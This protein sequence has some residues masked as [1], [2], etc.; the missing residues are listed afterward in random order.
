MARFLGLSQLRQ[1][2]IGRAYGDVLEVAVGTGINL[3]LYDSGRL[4]NYTGLDLSPGMLSQACSV[5]S[6]ESMVISGL[7]E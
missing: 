5:P 3:P 7:P 1:R 6:E 4:S 2:L